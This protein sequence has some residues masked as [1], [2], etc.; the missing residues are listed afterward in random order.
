MFAPTDRAFS[1]VDSD[2][3]DKLLTEKEMARALVLRHTIPGALYTAGMRFYQ[4]R[5]SMEKGS[6]I[7][8]HKTN[9]KITKLV[10]G[11]S[12]NNW[13]SMRLRNDVRIVK[14]PVH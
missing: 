7:V 10:K 12:C 5:D 13:P 11:P 2:D 6:S 1:V 9:G 8:L 3:L 4:L 14:F